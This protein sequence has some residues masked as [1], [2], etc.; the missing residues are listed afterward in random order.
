M[1]TEAGG[2]DKMSAA[3][4]DGVRLVLEGRI[5]AHTAGPM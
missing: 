3:A 4:G 1:P 2:Y 5:T